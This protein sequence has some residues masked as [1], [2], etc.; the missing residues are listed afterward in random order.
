ME[1]ELG[2]LQE[3]VFE[4]VE[5]EQDGIG[6]ELRLRIAIGEVQFVSTIQLDVRQ[7]ADGTTQQVNLLHIVTTTSLTTTTNGIEQRGVA[8]V[9]L[10]IAQLV[11]A[12]SQY[13]R[14]WQLLLGKV[15]GEIDEG[16]IFITTGTHA[17][18][19]T[20]TLTIGQ[21]VILTIAASSSEAHHILG[22]FALPLLV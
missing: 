12:D 15:L 17:A 14:H 20:N 9:G 19:H 4:V 11:V 10:D 21:S 22:L 6:V 7:F 16:V 5:V 13:L 8:Q 2:S 18:Y 3:T 1:V